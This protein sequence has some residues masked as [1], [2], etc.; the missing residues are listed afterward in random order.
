MT[1][2]DCKRQ[3]SFRDRAR[4][5]IARG[6]Q[7]CDKADP[8]QAAECFVAAARE[9]IGDMALFEEAKRRALAAFKNTT[10]AKCPPESGLD[11]RRELVRTQLDR[12]LEQTVSEE[13]HHAAGMK[14][15]VADMIG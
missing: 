1:E 12:L 8:L 13:E 10:P 4:T 14:K 7:H 11:R 6:I 9:A 15:E 2:A 5:E 3:R